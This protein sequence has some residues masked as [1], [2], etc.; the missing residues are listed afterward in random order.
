M[1]EVAAA[2]STAAASDAGAGDNEIGILLGTAGLYRGGPLDHHL[3]LRN[4]REKTG[5]PLGN[6]ARARRQGKGVR[7]SFPP[8]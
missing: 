6:H 3:Q 2:G 8:S 7:G 1:I 5:S 4:R